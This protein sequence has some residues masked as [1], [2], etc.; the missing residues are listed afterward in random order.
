MAPR[1]KD[2]FIDRKSRSIATVPYNFVPLRKDICEPK[3]WN[4]VEIDKDKGCQDKGKLKRLYNTYVQYV[5]DCGEHSG[6]IEVDIT[7]RTSTLIGE[8]DE[9]TNDSA[10]NRTSSFFS[11][12]KD[13]PIIPGSSLRGMVRNLFKTV[14]A[15]SF[16]AGE[17]FTEKTLYYRSFAAPKHALGSK[18]AYMKTMRLRKGETR[19]R[20][21]LV[22]IREAKGVQWR[23]YEC[24]PVRNDKYVTRPPTEKVDWSKFG[25]TKTVE[26]IIDCINQPLEENKKKRMDNIGGRVD[27]IE[28]KVNNKYMF[29]WSNNRG[30]TVPEYVI[31][32]Y[33]DDTKR[34]GLDVLKKSALT[35]SD[36]A[37]FLK[38]PNA[39]F[40]APCFFTVS[41]N[42]VIHFGAQMYY[43]I[44]YKKSIEKHV[45]D[46]LKTGR[47]DYTDLVFGLKEYWGGRVSFEDAK[48]SE[49]VLRE[50]KF[51]DRRLQSVALLGP[52]PTSFQLYLD[53]E[54]D[55]LCLH[56]DSD[57]DI[58]GV[59]H[60][61]HREEGDNEGA[62][63]VTTKCKNR[64]RP[65]VTFKGK[66][67]FKSLTNEEL[68]ALCKVLFMGTGNHGGEFG[69]RNEK[70]QYKIGKGK[71][72][73][74]GSVSMTSKLFLEREDSYAKKEMW[75]ADGIMPLYN[76]IPLEGKQNSVDALIA[77][78]DCYTKEVMKEQHQSLK[79]GM[80]TLYKMMNPDAL[81][82]HQDEKTKMMPINDSNDKRFANRTSLL[83]VEKFI[84]VSLNGY[85]PEEE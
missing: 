44:P 33:R 48:L 63:K 83:P 67:Y 4:N 64:V 3:G 23:M 8:Y 14:T 68:G 61:W 21:F 24:A 9:D 37:E 29:K 25:T 15:S 66:V 70:R 53:Q 41:G 31:E 35:G 59:K 32:A 77:A 62:E 42:Q 2:K 20:G 6:Y 57:A 85:L 71:S 36:V 7:T 60:Y 73:G 28:S 75:S 19:K 43:R 26:V 5:H 47:V 69:T 54:K 50:N 78:F 30:Y 38:I 45:P 39:D 74:W 58:R 80:E 76:E 27:D 40:V 65:G 79:E 84:N 22:R 17:D 72:I 56:W 52:N 13:Q 55:D 46:T 18:E 82:E 11:I 81:G 1:V 10:G 16:R 12:Q 34:V 51:L 49:A